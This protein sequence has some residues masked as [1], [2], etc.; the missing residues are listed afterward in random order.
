MYIQRTTVRQTPSA[1]STYSD[2]IIRR[3]LINETGGIDNLSEKH[4]R[5]EI[6]S[7]TQQITTSTNTQ[8]IEWRILKSTLYN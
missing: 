8:V 2:I 3:A 4:N 7:V 5:P 1:V 6:Y